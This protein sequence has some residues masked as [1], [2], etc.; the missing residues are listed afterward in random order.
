MCHQQ[1]AGV[2]QT[3]IMFVSTVLAGSGPDIDFFPVSAID[4][5]DM[6]AQCMECTC[7]RS[8]YHIVNAAICSGWEEKK[9]A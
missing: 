1:W 5:A 9:V 4:I 8:R 2:G 3:E 6:D 7:E